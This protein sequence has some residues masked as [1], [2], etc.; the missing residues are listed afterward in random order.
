MSEKYSWKKLKYLPKMRRLF[1]RWV[2]EALTM[3]GAIKFL[4]FLRLLGVKAS[5]NGWRKVTSIFL[6]GES[7]KFV[8]GSFR[9]KPDAGALFPA[10]SRDIAAGRL[11]AKLAAY[12]RLSDD[13][14][15]WVEPGKF[16]FIR[17]RR[18]FRDLLYVEVDRFGM[19]VKL[20]PYLDGIG[21]DLEVES[22]LL[23]ETLEFIKYQCNKKHNMPEQTRAVA[24]LKAVE[25]WAGEQ[26][27]FYYFGRRR[28]LY[29]AR[30]ILNAT[31]LFC[32]F[33]PSED[34][35]KNPLRE[36]F[37]MPDFSKYRMP[38][39]GMLG[40]VARFTG[41]LREVDLWCQFNHVA[42]DGMPMQEF[43]SKL[44][45]DWGSAG[46]VVF[47][48]LQKNVLSSMQLRYAGEGNFRALFFT[49]FEPLL[50]VRRYLNEHY[51][52]AMGGKAAV[53]G[54]IMWG[55][56][57]HEVF[58]KQKIL[59]PVDAG[60]HNNDRILNLLM[61]R[62]RQFASENSSSPLED[63]CR[64]Q[65]EMNLRLE[66]ARTGR[67]AV[68]EFLELCALMHPFFYHLARKIWPRALN[69]V[70]GTAGLSLL[71]D[72]EIFI[73]PKT[74]FQSY[75]FIALGNLKIPTAD[76]RTAAAVSIAGSRKQIRHCLEAMRGLPG[77]LVGML[78]LQ[79]KL[80]QTGAQI[81]LATEKLK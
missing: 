48:T 24:L 51:Q 34:K 43:L 25:D 22:P 33:M 80:P 20:K 17:R 81:P 47:P 12:L 5:A 15:Y 57:R 11:A 62:P 69:E 65:K 46:D 38:G 26:S 8:L 1:D 52:Q 68:S 79:D 32:E 60:I 74:E 53:A 49:D 67:G 50:A 40:A 59:L 10:P 63:Y 66:Q 21:R 37:Q 39:L 3:M 72:A 27:R 16:A 54:L 31:V 56:S 13:I 77:D 70:L 44:K 78:G 18:R 19:I 9:L 7:S 42:A 23:D 64:F 55:L 73:A 35:M 36:R 45:S 75:G 14:D 28:R 4:Q 2:P 58:A 41:D 71:R 29:L 61:I 76:K 30:R 6:R